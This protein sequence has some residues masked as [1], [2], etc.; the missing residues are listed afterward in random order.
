MIEKEQEIFF[1]D[2]E[3]ETD[4]KIEN[5][6]V[7][8]PQKWHGKKKKKKGDDVEYVPPEIT[9]QKFKI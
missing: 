2:Q 9:K 6:R 4:L 8:Y 1:F 3:N 7:R 5:K